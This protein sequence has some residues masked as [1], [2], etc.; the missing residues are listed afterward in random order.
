MEL[1]HNRAAFQGFVDTL[2]AKYGDDVDTLN[3]EWGLVYWSHRIARWDELWTP[4]GN[5]VP[6]YDLA[7]R[8]Y[9]S[10]DHDR[11]HRRA[12]RH[13]ARARAPRP[14]RHHLH[15]VQPAGVR[16]ARAQP[17]ELDVAAVN[18]YYAMQDA[19]TMPA[20][21]PDAPRLA[22]TRHSGAWAIHFQGDLTYAA[23]ARR[24]W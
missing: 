17:R 10:A 23:R 8:R 18:P 11:L 5:T 21:P 22:W 16:P 19:L 15:G 9:Q 13:R 1:F 12:G 2:R 3:R 20:A 24:S 6:S 14:V 7:W 4:D